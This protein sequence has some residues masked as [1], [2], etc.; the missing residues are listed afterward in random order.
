MVERFGLQ[1]VQIFK[2]VLLQKRVLFFHSPVRPLSTAI[3]SIMSL[4]PSLV[5]SGLDNA[6]ALAAS[7]EASADQSANETKSSEDQP[8][9]SPGIRRVHLFFITLCLIN[10]FSFLEGTR[11]K[12]ESGASSPGHDTTDDNASRESSFEDL[13]VPTEQEMENEV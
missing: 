10:F 7:S 12:N 3:L 2:L 13:K 9:S 4:F 5:E 8:S 11:K 6:T 1:V